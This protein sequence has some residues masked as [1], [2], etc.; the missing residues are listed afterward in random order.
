MGD[1]N[2]N[3]VSLFTRV[4]MREALNLMSGHFRDRSKPCSVCPE[5][6]SFSDQ[7]YKLVAFSCDAD[8]Y[9]EGFYVREFQYFV[10]QVIQTLKYS[11]QA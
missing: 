9:T 6:F 11:F 10:F 8:F 2:F 4:M 5:L 3:V 7:P 1:S